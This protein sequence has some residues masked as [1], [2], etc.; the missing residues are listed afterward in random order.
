MILAVVPVNRFFIRYV[1]I[2]I[3]RFLLYFATVAIHNPVN[4]SEKMRGSRG[5]GVYGD[6]IQDLDHSVG[7]ILDA[8]ASQ[9]G[10]WFIHRVSSKT[11]PNPWMFQPHVYAKDQYVG[12]GANT[13]FVKGQARL[14]YLHPLSRTN[15][16]PSGWL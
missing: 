3:N 11:T 10:Q 8:L 7:E 5:C 16:E 1:T 2:Q 4:T 12:S 15:S 13:T 9:K 14:P 6:F